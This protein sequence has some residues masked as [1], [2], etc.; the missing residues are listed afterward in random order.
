MRPRPRRP[1]RAARRRQ[2]GLAQQGI[3]LVLITHHLADIIPEIERVVMMRDGRI[4]ADGPK[5]ELPTRGAPRYQR[6][7]QRCPSPSRAATASTTFGSAARGFRKQGRAW[8]LFRASVLRHNRAPEAPG[9][10][11]PPRSH[12]WPPSPT[13]RP[14]AAR[15]KAAG[16]TVV[17][18]SAARRI[19]A[20]HS[21]G[22]EPR[23][24]SSPCA[25]SCWA[26]S[27]RSCFSAPSPCM[28][29]YARG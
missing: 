10:S 27:P 9:K 5:G 12:A 21:A 29:D 28:S 15:T 17:F 4:V 7:F 2:R 22:P 25:P 3:G 16:E 26:S 19:S 14:R 20:L 23:F 24:P 11:A 1:E 18:H 8:A 13:S 6:T